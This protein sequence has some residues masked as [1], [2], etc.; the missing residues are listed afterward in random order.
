MPATINGWTSSTGR[1]MAATRAESG[2]RYRF[3]EQRVGL[4]EQG[5]TSVRGGGLLLSGYRRKGWKSL[6]LG[7]FPSDVRHLAF[8]LSKCQCGRHYVTLLVVD[9]FE[10]TW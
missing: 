9:R 6:K 2:T 7:L 4:R 3:L 1:K 5:R 8:Y 10:K